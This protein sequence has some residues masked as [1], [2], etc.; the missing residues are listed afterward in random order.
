M[1]NEQATNPKAGFNIWAFLFSGP[2]Y[3]GKGQLKKGLLFSVLS[4]LPFLYV[5]MPFFGGFRAN[6]E[7]SNPDFNWKKALLA[8]VLN[9]IVWTLMI[10]MKTKRMH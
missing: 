3:A 6:K 1:S 8:G 2:Y 5:V 7:I 10:I 4:A 9:A